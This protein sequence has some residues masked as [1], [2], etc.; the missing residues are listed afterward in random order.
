VSGN[1]WIYLLLFIVVIALVNLSLV[2]L[3]RGNR[4]HQQIGL[5]RKFFQ[6]VRHPYRKEDEM[7]NELSKRVAGLKRDEGIKS[8]TQ[9]EKG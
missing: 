8:A 9:D 7:L 2:A 4:S 1:T 3:L 5:F 6:D